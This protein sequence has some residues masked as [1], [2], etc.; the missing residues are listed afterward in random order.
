M[1]LR[2]WLDFDQSIFHRFNLSGAFY[3]KTTRGF[4]CQ[5][6]IDSKRLTKND[7]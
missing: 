7:Q 2:Q 4:L 1:L 6:Y 3:D 5:N